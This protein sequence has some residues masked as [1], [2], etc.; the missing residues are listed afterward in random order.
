[1]LTVILAV[2]AGL[3]T[4]GALWL[5]WDRSRLAQR[6][7]VSEE[8]LRAATQRA[9]E[10]EAQATEL[11]QR[12]E[13]QASSVASLSQE[14]AGIRSRA[15]ANERAAEDSLRAMERAHREAMAAKERAVQEM[16]DR[17]QEQA[18]LAQQSFREVIEAKAAEAMKASSQEFLKLA[19]ENF[20]RHQQQA[21]AAINERV[22]PISDTLKRTEEKLAE[23]EKSRLSAYEELRVQ[24]TETNRLSDGLR[25]QTA[26]LANA[27]RK[28]HVRGRWGEVQL[29]RVAELAGMR[30]YCDFDLQASSR[31]AEG[32]L[33]RPDMVVRLPNDRC[34]AI[35]AKTNIEAY[36]DAVN[37]QSPEE[38][39]VHFERFARHVGEQA[40]ALARKNYWSELPGAL[41]F[42]VMFVPGDQFVDVALRLRP[43]LLEEAAQSGVIL[44]SPST[45]IGLLRAVHVGWR[46]KRLT[47][48]ANDLFKLGRE[49]HERAAAVFG[50]VSKIGTE[51]A[52]ATNAYNS[53][54]GS[55]E[56]RL[57]P[58]LRKFEE[59]GADSKA[60]LKEIKLVEV[61]P[62]DTRALPSAAPGPAE[63]EPR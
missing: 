40:Q 42:V 53:L 32:G 15:E 8:S 39:E 24:V 11:R 63:R 30:E 51:L 22:A 57:L 26:N 52:G 29:E 17:L 59:A 18:R 34:I 23:I 41:D 9:T 55:M 2:V 50:H 35:D 5:L 37:A 45:L 16:Q 20:A 7:A 19:G 33:R 48:Q 47:D 10:H 13:A 3:A 4:F 1:M 62:R 36:L 43:A 61:L 56:S 14:L 12:L 38:A 58:T 44:A 60:E 27:L 49:L 28:P 6:W 31:D 54:V 46:E 21:S 25:Q